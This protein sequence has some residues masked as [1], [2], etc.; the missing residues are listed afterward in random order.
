MC[1]SAQPEREHAKLAWFRSPARDKVYATKGREMNTCNRREVLRLVGGLSLLPSTSVFA[2]DAGRAAL[3]IAM[4]DLRVELD[5]LHPRATALVSFRVLESI[6][7]K[8]F[9]IDYQQDGQIRPMLAESIE[10]LNSTTYRV[11]LRKEVRF[12]GS[13]ADQPTFHWPGSGFGGRHSRAGSFGHKA[14]QTALT[15]NRR[16]SVKIS[17][18]SIRCPRI[19][20]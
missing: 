14:L 15:R 10:A 3:R 17:P 2:Q 18:S 19:L 5:P 4:Q 8:L 6:Y 9:A 1:E 20:T 7:D 13:Q 16:L 11:S 12:H